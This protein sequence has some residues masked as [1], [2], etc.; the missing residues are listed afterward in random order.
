M[1]EIKTL[2]ISILL[3]VACLTGIAIFMS[4]G[5]TNYGVAYTNHTM[6]LTTQKVNDLSASM[7]QTVSQ[8]QSP[9]SNPLENLW[10][11]AA[12]MG[13]AIL[14]IG[15]SLDIMTTAIYE[16][17]T[18]IPGVGWLVP[19]MTAI[20]AIMIGFALLAAFLRWDI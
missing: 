5:S 11:Q 18:Q 7:N 2:L 6:P 16:L 15:K 10:N 19:I 13:N 12:G 20:L 8:I 3:G 9:P 17:G 4:S 1:G 14:A